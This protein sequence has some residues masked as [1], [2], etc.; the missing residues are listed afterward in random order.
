M[1]EINKKTATEVAVFELSEKRNTY[2]SIL[3]L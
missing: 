1:P 2:W 3:T